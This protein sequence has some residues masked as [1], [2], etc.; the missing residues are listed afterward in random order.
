ME[1]LKPLILQVLTPEC[2]DEFFLHMNF[3]HGKLL[4]NSFKTSNSAQQLEQRMLLLFKSNQSKDMHFHV[5][6]S[7]PCLSPQ[8]RFFVFPSTFRRFEA[9]VY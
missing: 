9:R 1:F 8:R 3:F 7:T 4:A 5:L 6:R 2:Y